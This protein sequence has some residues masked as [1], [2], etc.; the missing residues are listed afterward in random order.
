[1]AFISWWWQVLRTKEGEKVPVVRE[2][3]WD[4]TWDEYSPTH[5]VVST[6]SNKGLCTFS[7]WHLGVS[8]HWPT[9]QVTPFLVCGSGCTLGT[10]PPSSPSTEVCDRR[11]GRAHSNRPV[12]ML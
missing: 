1:M 3:A 8:V 4:S 6:A 7:S 9:A 11:S 5:I 10:L 2:A 12:P